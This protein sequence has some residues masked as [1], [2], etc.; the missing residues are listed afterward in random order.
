MK[1][2]LIY[3]LLIFNFI[4]F[5]AQTKSEQNIGS[6]YL[7]YGNHILS[8][9][10]S[11]KTGFEERNYQTF[12]NYNLTLYLLGVNYKITNKLTAA[13]SYLYLDIDRTFDPDVAPKTRENRFYEQLSY[14]TKYFKIPFSHRFR[15]E[16]R[17]LNSLGVKTNI[18]RARY[19]IKAKLPLSKKF[20]I[21]ASNES[22]FNFKGK[23]YSENRFITAFGFKATKK[24]SLEAGYLGHYIN[25]L[26]LDR[27][28]VALYLKTD[29][30]KK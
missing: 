1:N 23:L 21:M 19:R 27:I 20:Y 17:F 3:T 30:R 28:Q 24:I 29:F 7:Y 11:L 12:Q 13:T 22:F 4:T 15:I 25:D 8:E 6:W 18:N 14:A 2:R 9:K 5:Q 10:W 16:H 26:H